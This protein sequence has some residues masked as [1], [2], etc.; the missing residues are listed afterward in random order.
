MAS[1]QDRRIFTSH[2]VTKTTKNIVIFGSMTIEK[3]SYFSALTST[4][5]R[6]ASA[7]Q[8]IFFFFSISNLKTCS[9]SANIRQVMCMRCSPEFGDVLDY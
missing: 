7:L 5:A 6:T 8:V 9:R 3:E 4:A 2:W 1:A